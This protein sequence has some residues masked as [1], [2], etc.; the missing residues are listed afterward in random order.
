MESLIGNLLYVIDFVWLFPA[1]RQYKTKYFALFLIMAIDD[2]LGLFWTYLGLSNSYLISIITLFAV[3]LSFFEKR[4]LKEHWYFFL[5]TIIFLLLG[6]FITTNW[7]N[8]VILTIAIIIIILLALIN[9][10]SSCIIRGKVDLFSGA[11]ILY[12][13]SYMVNYII[14]LIYDYEDILQVVVA[15]IILEI[16]LG[17]FFIIFRADDNKL[18]LNIGRQK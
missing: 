16:I 12:F 7:T 2:P 5:V 8:H 10:F 9:D 15:F 1:I 3:F 14:Y 4:V 13:G 18:L 6:Y 17:I 11:L